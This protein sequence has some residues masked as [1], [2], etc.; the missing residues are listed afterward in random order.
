M[1]L[2]CDWDAAGMPFGQ[3]GKG[4][5]LALRDD[6]AGHRPLALPLGELSPE[7]TERVLRPCLPSPSSLRSATSPIGRG[8]G[9]AGPM[10]PLCKGGTPA[11]F[12]GWGDCHRTKDG[13]PRQQSLRRFAPAMGSPNEPSAAVRLGRGGARERAAFRAVFSPEQSRADFAP[14]MHKGALLK[15]LWSANFGCCVPARQGQRLCPSSIQKKG[16]GPEGPVPF[17]VSMR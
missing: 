8:K 5:A 15:A 14:T 2:G 4:R 1:R 17:A 6:A 3:S 13:P 16:T 10:P 9:F 12:A 11:P 7:A